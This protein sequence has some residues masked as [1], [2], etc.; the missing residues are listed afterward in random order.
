MH[1]EDN[2]QNFQRGLGTHER[3]NATDELTQLGTEI[4]TVEM[5]RL[6]NRS[7]QIR[8]VDAV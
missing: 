2:D 4:E 7:V 1:E 3:A 5:L 6:E 8:D